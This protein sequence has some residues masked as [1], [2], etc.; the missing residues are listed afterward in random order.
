VTRPR[1]LDL[2]CGAGGCAVGYHRAGFDVVGVD[3][4]P[5]PNYPFEFHRYSALEILG[6]RRPWIP[7]EIEPDVLADFLQEWHSLRPERFD[8]I[9]ASPPC[10]AHS[11]VTGFHPGVRDE[12]PDLVGPTR[13]L[14]EQTGL[15]YVIENVPGAPIRADVRLC[16]E[17]FGLRV[18]RHRHFETHGF[19][20]MQPPHSRHHLRGA[21]TNT[22][23]REGYARG[24]YG[25]MADWRGAAEAMGIDW[26]GSMDEVAQAIPPA[27]T[28]HIGAFLYAAVCNNAQDGDFGQAA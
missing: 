25:H 15:P 4:R 10:K 22:E 23:T 27:Y 6:T 5:Q 8:A 20:V 18:H 16:G 14:L 1:I 7:S 17:M 2:F 24:V 21:E 3:I 26:M 19:F 12:H 28:A 11:R 9:H 13:E